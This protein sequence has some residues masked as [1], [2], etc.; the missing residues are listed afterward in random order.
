MHSAAVDYVSGRADSLGVFFGCLG[1]LLFLKA[2][3]VPVRSLRWLIF[4]LAW[5][6]GLLA[7]CSR[8]SACLWPFLFLL[9][10]FGFE[11]SMKSWQRWATVAA[12]LLLFATYFG[13]RQLPSGR[14][15]DGPSSGWSAPLRGV[16]M[17]RA[18]GDYGRL[19]LFPA[20]LHMER[21]VFSASAFGS[22]KAR[23]NSIELEYLSLAG[24]AVLAGFLLF[25]ARAAAGTTHPHFRCGLV[26]HRVSAH[27]QCGRAQRYCGG[28]LALL[29]KHRFY[30]LSGW[31]RHGSASQMAAGQCQFRL[32]GCSRPGGAKRCPQQ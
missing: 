6:V 20:N 30:H 7:L 29:A 14:P 5:A 2:R 4:G 28:A 24:L 1:C 3:T 18:L 11:R 27:L 13:L 9:Y 16:L 32:P 10:L 8:E 31:L 21:T 19:M 26:P 22:E 23:Q 17:L 15:V 25:F 12:C